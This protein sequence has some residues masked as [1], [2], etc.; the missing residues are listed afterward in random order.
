MCGYLVTSIMLFVRIFYFYYTTYCTY[1]ILPHTWCDWLRVHIHHKS[2]QSCEDL[3]KCHSCT[4]LTPLA[5]SPQ[6]Y[7]GAIH[8]AADWQSMAMPWN[9]FWLWLIWAISFLQLDTMF[10]KWGRTALAKPMSLYWS[11]LDWNL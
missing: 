1:L 5:W 7:R 2:F 4:T 8:S 9:H 6:H 10:W 11:R 3:W